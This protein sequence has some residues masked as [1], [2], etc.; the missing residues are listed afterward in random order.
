MALGLR[1]HIQPGEIREHWGS[2]GLFCFMLIYLMGCGRTALP[3]KEMDV[4]L[5][6]VG[7]SKGTSEREHLEFCAPVDADELDTDTTDHYIFPEMLSTSDVNFD[8]LASKIEEGRIERRDDGENVLEVQLRGQWVPLM[9]KPKR[10]RRLGCP[11]LYDIPEHGFYFKGKAPLIIQFRPEQVI[12][13]HLLRK[14]SEQICKWRMYGNPIPE[15][16]QIVANGQVSQRYDDS[17][18]QVQQL[19]NTSTGDFF[20]SV[21]AETLL[22]ALPGVR[23]TSSEGNIIFN[24][25]TG[26]DASQIHLCREVS[27]R[28]F[29]LEHDEQRFVE[30]TETTSDCISTIMNRQQGRVAWMYRQTVDG[31]FELVSKTQHFASCRREGDTVTNKA[32]T[33]SEWF[34]DNGIHAIVRRHQILNSETVRTLPANADLLGNL[35]VRCG[36]GMVAQMV[37]E[38]VTK[39]DFVSWQLLTED[40]GN[41]GVV[42]DGSNREYT[43]ATIQTNPVDEQIR[44][45]IVCIFPVTQW[46]S[47]LQTMTGGYF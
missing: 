5:H 18:A 28:V 38:T 33:V 46:D 43:L 4:Q 1:V 17:E 30:V 22:A 6:N 45:K 29:Q 12:V 15:N 26:Y 41:A 20:P 21:G 10:P 42:R 7:I 3:P 16:L 11:N 47:D 19:R 27:A 14:D 40:I 44:E 24:H 2:G 13:H 37:R 31:K 36:F 23:I 25:F 34:F 8:K 32:G 35:G 39:E 9:I